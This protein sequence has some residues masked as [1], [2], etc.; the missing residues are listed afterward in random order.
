MSDNQ[1][2]SS[3]HVGMSVF[4]QQEIVE[5]LQ[6]LPNWHYDS[7]NNCI[8]KH[9]EFKGFAKTMAYINAIAWISTVEKH[10]PDIHFGYNYVTVSYQS[11]EAG[12]ITQN[13]LICAG[14]VDQL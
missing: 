7:N 9:V 10:H 4:S 6:D 8:S 5:L 13:D 14:K 1:H 11:H 3:C 2:C 12:G